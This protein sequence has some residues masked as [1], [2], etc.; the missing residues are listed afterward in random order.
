MTEVKTELYRLMIE[1]RDENGAPVIHLQSRHA[2]SKEDAVDQVLAFYTRS[3]IPEFWRLWRV[4]V[5]MDTFVY[6]YEYPA[7]T[8]VRYPMYRRT[9]PEE[10]K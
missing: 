7:L 6:D 2:E 5:V 8:E 4:S 10:L 3:S 9:P 1:L